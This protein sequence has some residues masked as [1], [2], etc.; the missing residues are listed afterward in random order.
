M[1]KEKSLRGFGGVRGKNITQR[2]LMYALL[3]PVE[4][5]PLVV[6]KGPAGT[7]KTLL[8]L[9]CGLA[10]TYCEAKERSYD[11]ILIT[12][13]NTVSDNDLGFLPG[14]LEEK[15]SPL[16]APFMDNMQ[17]IFAGFGKDRDLTVAANQIDF[18]LQKQIVK[19]CAV[20]Y[21]RGRNLTNSYLI[22]DEAQNLSVHQALEIVSRAGD[23][24]KV[25]LL[26]DPDQIDSRYLDRR[27]NGL[28]F[29]A[30]KMKGSKLCAQ[31]TFDQEESVRS[32]LAM[33]A[34]IRMTV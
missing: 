3:A 8:A 15:M 20:G 19:I 16:L 24:T 5:I 11:Q 4:T 12:R 9:A 14:T 17:E 22:V 6:V 30:D 27:N 18:V 33:E 21:L 1:I 32:P 26:G 13:S 7:G 25:V 31:I 2:M 34:A 23:G 10:Q 28:V 29:T